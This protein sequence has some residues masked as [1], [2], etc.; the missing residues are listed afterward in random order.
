MIGNDSDYDDEDAPLSLMNTE[1]QSMK[2]QP[3][4]P[5]PSEGPVEANEV[6]LKSV[7]SN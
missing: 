7:Q 2:L 3:D 5:L 1:N 6:E 4:Q